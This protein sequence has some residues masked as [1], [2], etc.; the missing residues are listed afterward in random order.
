M[1]AQPS[2][3]KKP[4]TAVAVKQLAVPGRY[5]DGNGLYLVIDTSGARRWLLRTVVHGRR[6]DIGLGS[7]RLVPLSDARTLATSM[8]RIARDGGDPLAE[9]RK[10]RKIAPSFKAAAETVHAETTA[11]WKNKRHTDSWLSSLATY[12]FPV[13]GHRPVDQI[14]DGRRSESSVA[15]LAQ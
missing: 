5:G 8:R 10:Q 3:H 15:D 7:A 4:L 1:S 12:A 11:S 14:A 9:R 2:P 13:I 6:R